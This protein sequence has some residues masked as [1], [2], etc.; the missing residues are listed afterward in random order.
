MNKE[1]ELVNLTGDPNKN[2]TEIVRKKKNNVKSNRRDSTSIMKL[3]LSW[4][5]FKNIGQVGLVAGNRLKLIDTDYIMHI[6][7]K[8]EYIWQVLWTKSNFVNIN[9]IKRVKEE[10]AIGLKEVIDSLPDNLRKKFEENIELFMV[11]KK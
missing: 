11:P 4:G 2:E 6:P 7:P 1:D 5:C 9:A 3:F 10:R 8:A